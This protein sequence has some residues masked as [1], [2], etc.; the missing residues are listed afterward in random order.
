MILNH[1]PNYLSI[2]ILNRCNNTYICNNREYETKYES[3]IF[4]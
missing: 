3:R 4:V 2:Y 1:I